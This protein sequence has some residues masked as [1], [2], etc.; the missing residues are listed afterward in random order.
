[1]NVDWTD[2][3]LQQLDAIYEFYAQ[4]SAEYAL[5]LVDRITK[6]SIQIALF[7]LSGRKVPEYNLSDVREMIEGQYRIIYLIQEDRIEVLAL[8]HTSREGIKPLE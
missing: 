8:L 6:R 5:R 7:P 3:A 2:A 1:M 4:T